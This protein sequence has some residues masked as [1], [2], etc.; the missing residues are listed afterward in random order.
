MKH[1]II[2]STAIILFLVLGT[3]SHAQRVPGPPGMDRSALVSETDGTFV[4]ETG[5][6]FVSETGGRST[7]EVGAVR[8]VPSEYPTVQAAI[9]AALDG[10]TVLVQPGEY[11][12]NIDFLEKE[13]VL[14]SDGDGFLSTYDPAPETTI[15]NGGSSGTVVTMNRDGVG[16][17]RRMELTGFTIKQGLADFGGGIYCA[18]D[19]WALIMHNIITG[20]HAVNDGGGLFLSANRNSYV[21]G[22]RFISNSAG[23]R[24]GGAYLNAE[25]YASYPYL[26]NCLVVNN[27]ADLGGGVFFHNAIS[28][29]GAYFC[30]ISA[31]TATTGGGIYSL[32]D[33]FVGRSIIWQNSAGTAPQIHESGG[34]TVTNSDVE[35][36]WSG[37]GNIDADPLFVD[38]AANDFHLQQDPC[39]PGVTDN[40]C[41]DLTVIDPA[42]PDEYWPFY[43]FL[44]GSTRT[45][46]V[47]DAGQ[48]MN[49]ETTMHDKGLDI[50]YHYPCL[51]VDQNKQLITMGPY[52]THFYIYYLDSTTGGTSGYHDCSEKLYYATGGHGGNATG[53]DLSCWL[54]S[55]SNLVMH[56]RFD[57][58]YGDLPR[59][60]PDTSNLY[61]WFSRYGGAPSPANDPW[62]NL[63][64]ANGGVGNDGGM[65]FDDGGYQHWMLGYVYSDNPFDHFDF[66]ST[67]T[68]FTE[69]SWSIDP[70]A[71]F[72]KKIAD[73]YPVGLAIWGGDP[74]FRSH[75]APSGAPIPGRSEFF[76]FHAV[77]LWEVEKTT[78]TTGFFTITDSDDLLYNREGAVRFQYE[79][80]GD[81]LKI[82]NY[83][84][85]G[86]GYPDRD[87]WVN[88]GTCLSSP[89]L[90]AD[91][92]TIS[93]SLG[94]A[95]NFHLDVGHHNSY[96]GERYYLLLGSLSGT[97]PGIPLPG[98]VAALPLVWD[99]FT[100]RVLGGLNSSKYQNFL[101]T[102]DQYGEAV[103]TMN[104]SPLDP[105]HVG[106]RIYFAFCSDDPFNLVS[107]PIVVEIVP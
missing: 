34:L 31:N 72:Q 29:L 37:Q 86:H 14:R 9:D 91:K 76:Y 45:D 97:E 30:T 6:T 47:A 46:H 18:G 101:G 88:Y 23:S 67:D 77:T 60:S 13:L 7:D 21:A 65:T 74:E 11:V 4:S 70:I 33:S 102:Y 107:N 69:E 24:G 16:D 26:Y 53:F 75:E 43:S 100:D 8:K 80:A 84:P 22:N 1:I 10:D 19:V 92:Y 64:M 99:S 98:G 104:T 35:G 25:L 12:E 20:N 61:K 105:K 50:G 66:I 56:D 51:Y 96:G 55:A 41:V 58:S 71:W 28:S 38:P 87:A 83:L 79:Y 39:Q 85:H 62:G 49:T 5:G 90:D 52:G 93:A 40:P 48:G 68:L 54:A 32:D 63:L 95:V 106:K 59:W 2:V 17:H 78:N 103:A 73:G 44:Y 27:T 81:R 3:D 94:G 42:D 36:G 82:L 89:T 15:L 57:Y